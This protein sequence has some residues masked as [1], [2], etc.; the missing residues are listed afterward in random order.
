MRFLLG[1]IVV[2]VSIFGAW[3]YFTSTPEAATSAIVEEAPVT[4]DSQKAVAVEM[5]KFLEKNHEAIEKKLNN[6]NAEVTI[7]PQIE[8]KVSDY[9][10]ELSKSFGTT[11]EDHALVKLI[12]VKRTVSNDMDEQINKVGKWNEVILKNPDRTM[13][14]AMSAYQSLPDNLLEEKKILGDSYIIALNESA[15]NENDEQRKRELVL[16]AAAESPF[17]EIITL[18]YPGYFEN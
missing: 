13:T 17:K 6:P 10:Y 3:K 5:A 2:V 16:R 1:V 8:E 18:Y 7:A 15:K 4:E 12:L 9:E 14:A 11:D